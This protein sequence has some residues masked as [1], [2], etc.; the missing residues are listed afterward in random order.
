MKRGESSQRKGEIIDRLGEGVEKNNFSV[1][2]KLI[3]ISKD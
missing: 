2:E 1:K 3:Q